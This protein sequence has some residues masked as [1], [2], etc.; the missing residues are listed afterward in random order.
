M[1]KILILFAHPRFEKSK[2]SRALL[3]NI[4]QTS[5]VTLHDLYEEYPD[6]NIDIERE[7]TL[8]LNHQVIVWHHPL[9]MYSAPALLKQWL[10]MVLEHG[11]AHGSRGNNLKDKIIFNALTI[12][13][14]KEAYTAGGHNKYT[15]SEFLRPF[16][17]TA[18][19]CKMI[20]LP[21]F[22]VHG[23]HLLSP[24]DLADYARLYQTLLEKLAQNDFDVDAMSK[25][26]YL[27]DWLTE[28]MGANP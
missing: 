10:D 13:G 11:W 21:P 14:T 17:Q 27:N 20:Y 28:E 18:A 19:L 12:G 1:N 7:K 25:Y 22:A 5:G 8:L 3:K 23:T 9:Y 15:I 6:F 26:D 2:T 4:R 16:A 24:S